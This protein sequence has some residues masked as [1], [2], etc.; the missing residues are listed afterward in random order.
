M[1]FSTTLSKDRD[2][3][4]LS[5]FLCLSALLIGLYHE[6]LTCLGSLFLLWF[7]W[8][9][10]RTGGVRF[11][12]T[13]P[14]VT[15]AVIALLYGVSALWAADRGMAMFGFARF[16]PLP[17]FALALQQVSPEG[18]AALRRAV[19]WLGAALALFTGLLAALPVTARFVL[20]NGRLAGTFQYPNTFGLFLL[21]CVI[22]LVAQPERP[23]GWIPCLA[24]LLAG[25]AFTGSRTVF[26]LLAVTLLLLFLL[27]KDRAVRFV[28]AGAA[29]LLVLLTAG[30]GLLTGDLSAWGRYLTISL[31]SSTLQGRLLY[32]E[33]ALPVI[34]KH[35][36]GLGYMGY[37]ATVGSFQ[38]GV[39]S[40]VHVHNELLQLM[41]DIGWL[42][43]A[44]LLWTVFRSLTAKDLP[45]A[46]KLC[47]GVILL[48]SLMDFDLQ[49]PVVWFVL[50]L[51]LSSAEPLPKTALL[52][53]GVAPVCAL[54]AC[55]CLY[56]GLVSGLY[57]TGNTDLC[58]R[59]WPGH[60]QANL[61]LLQQAETPE[62]MERQADRMLKYSPNSALALS[63]KARAAYAKGNFQQVIAFKEQAISMARYSKEEY[64]DY[65][66][67]LSV[68]YQLYLQN[69]DSASA[70]VCRQ[71]L[72]SIPEQ[73]EA[74]LADTSPRAWKITDKPDLS[75]PE[76]YTAFLSTLR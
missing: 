31:E 63:A 55:L 16:L 64:L 13:L 43:A 42:P 62:E 68:G 10:G 7:L 22:L 40:L 44:L 46:C 51:C 26:V 4:L 29:A 37:A 14:L 15:A 28:L 24:L 57:Y 67:M 34:L 9:K 17:L 39:Y 60:T 49:Y 6:A 61:L 1:L 25:I 36:L 76:E 53:R 20:V 69:G 19:P 54:L 12:P 27:V 56:L 45:L 58:A 73:M 38:T 8:Q 32:W 75:L 74:V 52:R 3:G 35:P 71:K 70:E 48:H 21:A 5:A 18:H 59:L 33:D 30:Y 50:L 47:T 72:L 2:A 11:S 41:L 65:F 66:Q 23:R